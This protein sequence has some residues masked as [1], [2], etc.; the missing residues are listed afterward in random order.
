MDGMPERPREV[1]AGRGARQVAAP[2]NP[3]RERR[4]APDVDE[5]PGEI[6]TRAGS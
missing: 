3:G 4:P 2:G 6:M 1:G 5:A